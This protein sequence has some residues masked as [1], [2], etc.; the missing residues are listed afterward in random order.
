MNRIVHFLAGL[1]GRGQTHCLK[2]GRLINPLAYVPVVTLEKAVYQLMNAFF[3]GLDYCF[4]YQESAL[5]N[6]SS[7]D[8]MEDEAHFLAVKSLTGNL[9]FRRY[10]DRESAVN[11]VEKTFIAGNDPL[12]FCSSR[13]KI[14]PFWHFF[15][16]D[17]DWL[18]ERLAGKSIFEGEDL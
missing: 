15:V 17:A 13:V 11:Y 14:P 8:E 6:S 4:I 18:L 16:V 10:R 1:V 9:V 3:F 12:A 5:E 2:N 7:N